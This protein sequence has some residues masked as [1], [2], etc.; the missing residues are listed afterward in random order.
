MK[1]KY[2]IDCLLITI[3]FYILKM[4]YIFSSRILK[5]YSHKNYTKIHI[6]KS[7]F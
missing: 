5:N 7:I 3:P 1:Y 6:F 4:A 2:K